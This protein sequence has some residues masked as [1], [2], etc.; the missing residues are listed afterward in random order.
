M[1][2]ISNKIKWNKGWEFTL[3][4]LC[5][6]D[7]KKE[8]EESRQDLS[9]EMREKLDACEWMALELPHDWLIA[10][11]TK[12]YEDGHG[13]YRKSFTHSVKDG[14][15][16]FI[17]F[18]GVYMDS[19]YYVNGKNV[20]CWKYGYSAHTFDI[21]DALKDGENELLVGVRHRSPNTRWYSGAGIFR[22][23]FYRESESTYIPENGVY[24]S[25]QKQG[26]DYKLIIT[27]GIKGEK[28]AACSMEP[29]LY[30][31]EGREVSM[32]KLSDGEY[33]VKAP[34]EWDT[35]DPYL[36]ELKLRLICEGAVLEEHVFSTGFRDIR[37]EPDKGFFLNGR[38]M[39]LNGVCD[40]HDLGALGSAFNKS[41]MRR[42]ITTLKKM[43]VNAMRLTHNMAAEGVIELADEMGVLLI[44]EA[45][46]MWEWKK[47]DYDYA[48]FFKDW[49]AADVESWITRDRNH[50]SVI[51]WS[52]GN[53]IYDTHEGPHGQEITKDLME[54]VLKY[55]PR[56]NARATIGSNY[57]PWEGA[58]KCADILKIA[59]YNYAEKCYEEHH[60]EHP[61]WVIY[62]SETF[63]IVQSRGVYHFPLK[64]EIMSDDDEQ[65]SALGNSNTSWGAKT[66]EGCACVDR[67]TDF[68]MGQFLWTDFDY[69]GEPTPYH[70]KNSYFGLVDTAG[71]PK[72]VYFLWQSVWTDPAKAP[73]IHVFPYWDFN[74]GQIVDVRV[75]SNLDEVELFLNGKSLGRQQLTHAKGSG[76]KLFADYSIPYEAGTLTAVA[77]DENGKEVCRQERKSFGDTK[78]L[79]IDVKDSAPADPDEL[80]FAAF[81][82]VDEKGNPVENACDRIMVEVEGPA[83]LVGLDNGDSTD[84][85][86]FKGRNKRLF[87]G[88]LLAMIRPLGEAG[89]IKIKASAKNV[90]GCEA[91]VVLAAAD[92]DVTDRLIKANEECVIHNGKKDEIPVRKV[93]LCCSE[94]RLITPEH[95][96][97]SVDVKILPE[98]AEDKEL[99]FRI[100]NE[101]GVETGLMK[102]DEYKD[103]KLK[104][105]G[106]S[107]GKLRLRAMSHCGSDRIRL[108]SE[109]ELEVTGFGEGFLDPYHFIS[110]GLYSSA[111]GEIGSGNE[112]GIATSREGRTVVSFA[113]V[114][115]G[116]TGSD[117]ITIPLFVLDSD[118]V[119]LR[120]WK[121]IPGEEDAELVFDGMYCR[122]REW[123][124][125][126]SQTFKCKRVLTGIVTLSFEFNMKVH[127]KGF[128]FA[129]RQRAWMKNSAADADKVY[130]DS[131]E[132]DG[133]AV[134]GIGNNVTLFFK[135]MDF[136]EKQ[137]SKITITGRTPLSNNTIHLKYVNEEGEYTEMFEFAGSEES[138]SRTFDI[139]PV[140]GSWDV[141]FVFLPGS[142]FDFESFEFG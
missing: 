25:T 83:V 55:D 2:R 62:G 121:G 12:L 24:L 76:H 84:E 49:H 108:I 15:R 109:L 52:I 118:E 114:D 46:D 86:S 48:R 35:E 57:M 98:D 71:F 11:A 99:I 129:K 22:D 38:N 95:P 132:I 8:D 119:P 66:Y 19:V 36:Y 65:C 117:E 3:P 37:M 80:I 92:A 87:N 134:R 75:C 61:D 43:G 73:M 23:V 59:G 70:T 101:G 31:A 42:K 137:A 140:S 77:Y 94:G 125:Y 113:N 96:G 142:N 107:D 29:A 4:A 116:R 79:L 10:D 64:R 110:A 30:D 131:F 85:D 104:L 106:V 82:A 21:T 78:K 115:F 97:V 7:Q 67:D 33:L 1:S 81:S 133:S 102:I 123:N 28:A 90:E 135:D 44:S 16:A 63:S 120:I 74:P 39:K 53:E 14:G 139:K 50:P 122:K 40:H 13:W 126:L 111:E 51:M 34:H 9:V 56:K 138:I 89:T 26:D 69:I 93:E 17:T 128:E 124:V 47:T 58:Q 5:A 27:A 54:L 88:Q 103:G 105:S 136:G 32:E 112:K 100:T 45:F 127:F 68:S 130:G 141:N 20:G 41:A 60:K 91:S 18:D 6:Y 72:D